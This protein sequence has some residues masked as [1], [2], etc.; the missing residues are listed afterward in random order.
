VHKFISWNT[1]VLLLV[2]LR[3]KFFLTRNGFQVSRVWFNK[4]N[5]LILSDALDSVEY[6]GV[7]TILGR[8]NRGYSCNKFCCDCDEKCGDA[9][10]AVMKGQEMVRRGVRKKTRQKIKMIQDKQC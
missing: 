2:I 7:K 4:R 6:Y 10:K 1:S 9:I 3:W 5:V 8:V